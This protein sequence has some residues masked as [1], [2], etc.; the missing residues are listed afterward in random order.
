MLATCS[1]KFPKINFRLK[2]NYM[3][4]SCHWHLATSRW[5]LWGYTQGLDKS[6]IL[7]LVEWWRKNREVVWWEKSHY[8]QWKRILIIHW[9]G[10]AYRKL[11]ESR[12]D[13]FRW[14]LFEKTDCL[15]TGDSSEDAKVTSKEL[16]NYELQPS[17]DIDPTPARTTSST[18]TSPEPNEDGEDEGDDFEGEKEH[19]NVE[20]VRD[21]DIPN[22]GWIF[23]LFDI[24]LL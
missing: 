21:H 11:C 5:W 12:Y 18:V 22:V 3:V 14:R 6:V 4:W 8:W 9:A 20:I 17:I 10:S 7:R 19:E 13:N 24:W 2:G 15:I 16:L 23:D 1:W